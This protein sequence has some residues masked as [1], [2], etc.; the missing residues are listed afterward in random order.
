MTFLEITIDGTTH[1]AVE[2]T[3]HGRDVADRYVMLHLGRTA[4][5]T[6]TARLAQGTRRIDR[7]DVTA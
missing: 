1:G 2:D 7:K 6:R 3:E 5:V 4:Q